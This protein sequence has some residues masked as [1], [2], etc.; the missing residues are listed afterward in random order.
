MPSVKALLISLAL[1]IVPAGAR[2]QAPKAWC[3]TNNPA[4]DTV[5]T[6]LDDLLVSYGGN[7]VGPANVFTTGN[8]TRWFGS[9]NGSNADNIFRKPT[10]TDVIGDFQELTRQCSQGGVLQHYNLIGHKGNVWLL[11]NDGPND[12]PAPP[13]WL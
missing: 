11:R 9:Y 4:N 7:C 2:P 6:Q 5:R 10:C 13:S 1:T 8:T 3:F 12:P